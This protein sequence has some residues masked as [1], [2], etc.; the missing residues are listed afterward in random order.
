MTTYSHT[1][2]MPWSF[3]VE[4]ER[5]FQR[6]LRFNLVIFLLLSLAIPF[7]PLP[8]KQPAAEE[9]LPPRLAR[10]ILEQKPVPPPPKPKPVT[11][12]PKPVPKK[13]EAPKP[14]PVPKKSKPRVSKPTPK[15]APAKKT[16]S[17][18]QQAEQSGLLA[19]KD[20]LQALRQETVAGSLKETRL[21]QGGAQA[22]KTE[23]AILTAGTTTASD[24]HPD[25]ASQSRHRRRCPGVTHHDPGA[26]SPRYDRHG[27]GRR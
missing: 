18:R 1:L 16:V 9:E 15:P 2:A 14:K 5:R 23:R 17:A 7:L 8:E 4:D 19:M 27:G 10:L 25:G 26:E 22:R 21:S 13:A 24:R 12:P 3:S 11:P 20:T 6:I